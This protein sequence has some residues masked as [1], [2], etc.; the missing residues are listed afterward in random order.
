M[1]NAYFCESYFG[2]YFSDLSFLWW[3]ELKDKKIRKIIKIFYNPY[4]ASAPTFKTDEPF[5]SKPTE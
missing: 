5:I 4:D 2:L 3:S 1:M